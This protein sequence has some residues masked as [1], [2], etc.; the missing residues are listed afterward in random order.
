MPAAVQLTAPSA[1]LL[2]QYLAAMRL[3]GRKTGRSTTSAARSFCAKIERAGG[4]EQLT[5]GRQSDAISKA[6]SFASWLLVTG[7]L[8]IDADLMTNVDLRLGV[9]ARGHC[10]STYTWFLDATERLH[11]KPFDIAL[12]WNAL[13]KVAAVTGVAPDRLTD[14]DLNAARDA[15]VAAYVNRGMPS[16]GRNMSAIFTRLQLTL[17]HTGQLNQP[18]RRSTK[19][20]VT[21][22]GWTDVPEQFAQTARRYVAQVELSLQPNTVKGIDQALREFGS[23]LGNNR[24]EVSSCADLTRSHIEDYKLWL[25][26]RHGRYTGRPLDR[27]TIKNRLINLHCFFDRVTEWGYPNPPQRPL[28]FTGDLPIVDKPLPRFLDDAAATKLMRTSR[29]RPAVPPHR[30][31]SRPHRHPQGRTARPHRRRRRPDRI[32]ILAA[33]PRRQAPQRP[34]HSAAP[35]A[36]GHARRLDRPPP[37]HR[38]AVPT[39]PPGEQPTR[40]LAA[41]VHRAK[42]A[43]PRGRDRPR[44]RPPAPAHPGDTGD[45]P[46]DEHRRDR[47]PTRSQ[48]PRHDDDL[49]PDRRQDRL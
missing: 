42:P 27:T 37:S 30:R 31:A 10:P 17:F 38:T 36:Q 13:M 20:L 47:R 29:P 40:E 22:A 39:P 4:W 26:A 9:V 6:R 43:V 24:P 2:E 1:T 5:P 28:I 18:K 45:Q 8:R 32:G 48:D 23:W 15:I 16:S 19:P 25:G 7:Q 12:Q 33:H 49:R 44:H 35:T 46:R 11:S 34:L 3:L 21:V 14:K 41:C